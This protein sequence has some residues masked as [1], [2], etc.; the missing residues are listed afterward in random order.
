MILV[1]EVLC[2][3]VTRVIQS[4][5]NT[6]IDV[7]STSREYHKQVDAIEIEIRSLCHIVGQ[8]KDTLKATIN[9]FSLE[10]LKQLEAV[11]LN[12]VHIFKTLMFA[13][14]LS[15]ESKSLSIHAW[16]PTFL[17][18]KLNELV[19]MSFPE[20][21]IP[22]GLVDILPIGKKMCPPTLSFINNSFTEGFQ[23]I[24]DT[25]GVPRYMEINPGVFCIITFP[26][27][28]GVMYGDVGHAS[29]LLLFT[30]LLFGFSKRLPSFLYDVF[31][32]ARYV[33]LFMSLFGI[34]CGFIYGDMFGVSLN[35][36]QSGWQD[37]EHVSVCVFG[38][39]S[40]WL[41]DP[42]AL[43]YLNSF[44]MKFAIIVG[45]CHM[46]LGL[47]CNLL[48][49]LYFGDK[50]GVWTEAIPQIVFLVATFGYMV[51]LIVV[52]WGMEAS[53]VSDLS[54][55][56]TMISMFL[57]SLN[58]NVLFSFQLGMQKFL[59]TVATV[60]VPVLLLGRPAVIIYRF[61]HSLNQ[62][63]QLQCDIE[64]APIVY[65]SH[66]LSLDS[67]DEH[68]SLVPSPPDYAE[69]AIHQLI[70][71]IEF[72]L[73]AVSNTASYLR[74][75]ALSLAHQRTYSLTPCIF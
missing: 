7:D 21:G 58:D 22:G 36:F 10:H 43:A 74:L 46:L 42:N 59:I 55:L 27:L 8:T 33:F 16:C 50:I 66:S 52:K 73:G 14:E 72:V 18:D 56:Q 53:D 51:L 44:K 6:F 61:K 71:T 23:T 26:F 20:Q 3:K 40:A 15:S 60:C 62:Y 75:W 17:L 12:D 28:F 38:F 1:G 41:E 34:Y 9:E 48:N 68:P 5:L 64:M 49:M 19:H 54:I 24:V 37:S 45:I 67:D 35:L 30:V 63:H 13:E 31:H 39:D 69:L 29:I 2:A 57:G 11:L 4:T 65:E 70:H 32:Q 25:Y 47:A